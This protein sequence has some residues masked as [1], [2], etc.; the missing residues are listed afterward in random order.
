MSDFVERLGTLADAGWK[1][2]CAVGVVSLGWSVLGRR[3]R[4]PVAV[5]VRQERARKAA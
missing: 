5:P 2:L 3:A 1:L 4:R